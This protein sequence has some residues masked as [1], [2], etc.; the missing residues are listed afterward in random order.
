M[1]V[2]QLSDPHLAYTAEGARYGSEVALAQAAQHLLH[3]PSLPDAVVVTGDLADQGRAEEY[4]RVRQ[5]LSALPMPIYVIPGNHDDRSRMLEIFGTQG[6]QELPGFVQYVV[7]EGPLRLIALDTLILG[8]DGG[9]LSAVQFAWLE[10]R[11]TQ[12]PQHPTL[13]LMHHPPFLTGIPVTDA[14]GF[15]ATEAL[16]QLVARHPQIEGI[17]AGHVH[18]SMFRR[19]WGTVALTCGSTQHQL[20]P[21]L[22]RPLGFAA[23][24]EAPTC[25]IHVWQPQTGLVT[26][27]SRIG[28]ASP[29]ELLHDG[30]RW[31]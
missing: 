15:Q 31:V 3:L 23:R 26:L 12:A 1:I 28:E 10:D 9:T 19:F 21:D 7:D 2:A 27:T 22:R 4:A 30:Q 25:L 8:Q 11:L 14:I 18:S 13:L 29:V 16:G 5:V 24:E 6:T 20:V 17:A